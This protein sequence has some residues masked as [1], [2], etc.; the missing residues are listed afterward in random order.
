MANR[1]IQSP[2]VEIRESDLSLRTAQTGTT[3]YIAGFASEGPT[4]E[5]I[6]LGNISEFEQIYGTP[7]TPAE[8]YFYHSARAALNSTGSL[9]VNRLPYGAGSGQG[10]G[11]K[12][13]VLAYP[14]VVFDEGASVK[15]DTFELSGNGTYLLG[16]PTQK[17]SIV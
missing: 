17:W 13:S 1:T 16:R 4:D 10:F 5:V 12:V 3:T 7:K 6:G 15:S 11:S 2:G 8:R 14:S 9:L